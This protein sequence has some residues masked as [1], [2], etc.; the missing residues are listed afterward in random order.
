MKSVSSSSSKPQSPSPHRHP[1][2]PT[3][4][5]TSPHPS[6]P[7]QP[8]K[9]AALVNAIRIATTKPNPF[10]EM[11]SKGVRS[12]ATMGKWNGSGSPAAISTT[13]YTARKEVAGV[14]DANHSQLKD[15]LFSMTASEP[16][17]TKGIVYHNAE[18]PKRTEARPAK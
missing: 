10:T 5:G 8:L 16:V 2:Y 7:A 17:K 4:A 3:T 6:K 13:S 1:S 14:R 9:H 11:A 15:V 12:I 18:S